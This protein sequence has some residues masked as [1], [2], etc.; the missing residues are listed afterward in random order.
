[1]PD[2]QLFDMR[3]NFSREYNTHTK[4]K[5][6][7][8]HS[9]LELLAGFL[10]GI[11]TLMIICVILFFLMATIQHTERLKKKEEIKLKNVMNGLF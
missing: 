8:N 1:M 2:A 6:C 3:V 7:V 10:I 5:P 9:T 4:K 11:G